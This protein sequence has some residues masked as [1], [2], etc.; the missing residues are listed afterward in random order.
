MLDL[1][2]ATATARSAVAF[3]NAA[4]AGPAASTLVS[5]E[6]AI[7]AARAA[8]QQLASQGPPLSTSGA[9]VGAD[10]VAVSAGTVPPAVT[11]GSV[12]LKAAG[13]AAAKAALAASCGAAAS[14]SA[15]PQQGAPEP[16]DKR[17]AAA[18]AFAQSLQQ[19]KKPRW[20]GSSEL[21]VCEPGGGARPPEAEAA[22]QRQALAVSELSSKLSAFRK[23]RGVDVPASGALLSL[24]VP[25][26]EPENGRER[27]WVGVLIGKEG[28]NKR[29]FEQQT[30][31]RI[32][33]RGKGAMLRSQK[34]DDESL[35]P[36]HV[37]LEA[38]SQEKLDDARIQVWGGLV[39]RVGRATGRPRSQP[40]CVCRLYR[41]GGEVHTAGPCSR[42]QPCSACRPNGCRDT[43]ALPPSHAPTGDAP[44]R[45]RWL[46]APLHLAAFPF[47]F[48]LAGCCTQWSPLL[49]STAP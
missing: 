33:L 7:A 13:Q 40:C 22:K 3:L 45:C 44:G 20:G 12:D 43:P 16:I 35:D 15:E 14:S 42:G 26:P 37:L 18:A 41:L 6:A 21:A 9:G 28:I 8:A 29:R 11:L 25:L 19:P 48:S 36:L 17:A 30:G 32:S 1:T 4:A 23:D 10:A 39:A 47:P 49:P 31:A 5:R 2:A 38:D 34:K 46:V 27:N 24:Q